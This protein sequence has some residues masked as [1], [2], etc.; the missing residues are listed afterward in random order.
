MSGDRVVFSRSNLTPV[1]PLTPITENLP[2]E[3]PQLSELTGLFV[4][5]PESVTAIKGL[6]KIII[7]ILSYIQNERHG[8]LNA[9]LELEYVQFINFS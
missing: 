5:K 9:L 1:T 2:G 4:Q 6:T 8:P 3:E 7:K